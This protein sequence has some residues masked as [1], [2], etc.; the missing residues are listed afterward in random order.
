VNPKC[1]RAAELGIAVGLDTKRRRL[2]DA[3]PTKIADRGGD[4]HLPANDKVERRGYALPV[5]EAD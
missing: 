5:N 4:V 3:A 2:T 1:E